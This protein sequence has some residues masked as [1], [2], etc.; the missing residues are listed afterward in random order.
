MSYR[1]REE[2]KETPVRNE[3]LN[4]RVEECE[5]GGGGKEGRNGDADT[6]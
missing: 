3:G 4:V 1:Q 5:K 6:E 2:K